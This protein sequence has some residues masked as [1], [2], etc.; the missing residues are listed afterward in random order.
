M[1]SKTLG[2][3]AIAVMIGIAFFQL[4]EDEKNTGRGAVLPGLKQAL[5]S[6]S[7]LTIDS[8]GSTVS[9]VKKDGRWVVGQLSGYPADFKTVSTILNTLADEQIAEVKTARPENHTKLGLSADG[10]EQGV[11]IVVLANKPFG[12]VIGKD[13]PARGSFVRRTDE[14]QVFLTETTLDVSTEAMDYVDDVFI[15]IESSEVKSVEVITVDSTL[16]AVRDEDGEMRISDLPEG[17]ELR[18]ATVADSLARMFVNLRFTDVVPFEP[19]HFNE[20]GKTSVSYGDDQTRTIYSEKI[21]GSY[22]AYIDEDWQFEISEFTFDELNKSLSDML[23]EE[24]P[25][26]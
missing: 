25:D 15:N 10:E 11:K 16:R 3:A 9:V 23:K 2:L 5:E 7:E 17:A 22:W 13:A 20:P 6:A 12:L 24:S 26:E 19:G 21:D 18:Y 1:N 8:A 14:D 4:Q